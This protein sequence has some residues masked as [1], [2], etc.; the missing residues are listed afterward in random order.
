MNVAPWL[1]A[2]AAVV[3]AV[4]TYHL[5]KVTREYVRL[6]HEL[7][8]PPARSRRT[9]RRSGQRTTIT[10]ARLW[11]NAAR[12]PG[13]CPRELPEPRFKRPIQPSRLLPVRRPSVR[14]EIRTAADARRRPRRA[15]VGGCVAR[16]TPAPSTA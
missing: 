3:V 5:V 4:L 14:D 1:Q 10:S 7:A 15:C 8:R 16:L 9:R 12:K 6:T 13:R 2:F 11:S